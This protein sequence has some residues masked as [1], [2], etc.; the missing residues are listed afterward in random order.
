MPGCGEENASIPRR[1]TAERCKLDRNRAFA[2]EHAYTAFQKLEHGPM[3]GPTEG[4]TAATGSKP[5][6]GGSI[7]RRG[8]CPPLAGIVRRGALEQGLRGLPSIQLL[9]LLPVESACKRARAV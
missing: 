7:E 4:R 8:Q 6:P 5:Y 9:I 3:E 1:L 2:P